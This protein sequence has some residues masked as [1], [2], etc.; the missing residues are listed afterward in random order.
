MLF[1]KETKSNQIKPNQKPSRLQPVFPLKE[2]M[3]KGKNQKKVKKKRNLTLPS[4]NKV[5]VHL[6]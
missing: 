3:L 4:Q 6:S 5:L 1:N 2:K